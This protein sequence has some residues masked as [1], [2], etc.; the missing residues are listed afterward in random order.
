MG[1]LIAV[2]ASSVSTGKE[3]DSFLTHRDARSVHQS[4][5]SE[6]GKV[7]NSSVALCAPGRLS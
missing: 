5:V 7:S 4:D 6:K 2:A 3:V 1:Q